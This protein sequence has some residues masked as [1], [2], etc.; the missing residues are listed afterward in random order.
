MIA[1]AIDLKNYTLGYISNFYSNFYSPKA[2]LTLSSHL[3]S[4]GFWVL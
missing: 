2:G 4:F 3:I 1:R